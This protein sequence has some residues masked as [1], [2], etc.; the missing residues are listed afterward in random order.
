VTIEQTGEEGVQQGDTQ[1]KSAIAKAKS[2]IAGVL[3]Q[4]TRKKRAQT[5]KLQIEERLRTVIDPETGLDVMRMALVRDI[6]VDRGAVSLVFQPSSP[7]CPLA[8]KLAF[9]IKKAVLSVPGVKTVS[10]GVEGFN[11]AEQLEALLNEK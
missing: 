5:Q 1:R 4:R 6:S 11:Q 8:F 10:V 9:E 7:V 2:T 3:W